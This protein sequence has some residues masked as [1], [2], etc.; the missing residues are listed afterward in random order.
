[1]SSDTQGQLVTFVCDE[2]GD[3]FEA[4]GRFKD[5]WEIARDDGWRCFKADDGDWQHRCPGCALI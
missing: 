4:A 1:M 5:V 2:C 3:T